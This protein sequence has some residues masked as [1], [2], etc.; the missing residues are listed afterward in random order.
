MLR[1]RIAYGIALAGAVLF[2]ICST[3]YLS[4]F[5]LILTL[6][7]PLFSLAL[8]LPGMRRCRLFLVPESAAAERGRPCT[9]T[10][11]LDNPSHLPLARLDF[12]LQEEN[13]LTGARAA[14]RRGMTGGSEGWHWTEAADSEHCGVLDCTLSAPRVCDFLGL[15][16][17]PVPVPPPA[18]MLVLPVSVPP[19]PLPFSLGWSAGNA[20]LRP[21]PGGG[22]GED[23]D[24]RDYRPGDPMRSVHWKLSSKRD[25]LI[26]RQTL[27]VQKPT[28]VLT[29]DL[30]GTPKT[31]DGVFDRLYALSRLLLARERPHFI[32]WV[33]PGSGAP[34]SRLIDSSSALLDCLSAAW[35]VRAPLEG[36]SIL[37]TA[38]QVPGGGEIQRYHIAAKKEAAQ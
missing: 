27:E 35:S 29:F 30:F 22:P 26:V 31:L 18:Q 1:R 20:R 16:S 8:S 33:H 37:D 32:Q 9:W 25:S 12:R 11:Q 4:A 19:E 10:V 28:L 36:R 3:G 21:R 38:V 6:I 23:Y 15:I 24:L 17:L 14:V 13:R 5:L 2:Q 34:N 7:F